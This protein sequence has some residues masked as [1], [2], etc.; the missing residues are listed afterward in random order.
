MLTGLGFRFGD[1]VPQPAE[2]AAAFDQGR[3]LLLTGTGALGLYQRQNPAPHRGIQLGAQPLLA[4]ALPFVERWQAIQCT[5]QPE[6]IQV[7][8]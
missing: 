2:H 1:A 7:L 4:L 5:P 3:Q 6:Q 8:R